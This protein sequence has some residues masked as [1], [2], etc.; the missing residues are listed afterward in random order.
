MKRFLFLLVLIASCGYAQQ[1]VSA[2]PAGIQ[3]AISCGP[4]DVFFRFSFVNFVAEQ[5]YSFVPFTDENHQFTEILD[6]DTRRIAFPAPSS[7]YGTDVISSGGPVPLRNDSHNDYLAFLTIDPFVCTKKTVKRQLP[8][9]TTT[10][11][12]ICVAYTIEECSE[13]DTTVRYGNDEYTFRRGE[14]VSKR[15]FD[16]DRL[17]FELFFKKGICVKA[18]EYDPAR[19]TATTIFYS[20]GQESRREI[21]PLT[22]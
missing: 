10:G 13:T 14:T 12:T 9:C 17:L 11:E 19:Q 4:D 8:L 16:G 2:I 1:P 18:I 5:V 15:E 7:I 3:D 21:K 22:E 6:V 20:E